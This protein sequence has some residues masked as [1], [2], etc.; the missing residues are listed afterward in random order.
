MTGFGR[1]EASRGAISATV[2]ARSVNQR[3]LKVS[4]RI[5]SWLS[6]LEPLARETVGREVRRGQVDVMVDVSG[7]GAR[8][9]VSID[10]EAVA[11]YLEEW[12]R[13]QH[14]L[15]IHGDLTIEVL[16]ASA[17][18]VTTSAPAQAPEDVWPVIEEALG[19][20]L[21]GLL[22]TRAVEGEATARDVLDRVEAIQ[23]G[24]GVIEERAPA[25]VR[26]HVERVGARVKD[27]LEGVGSAAGKL[28][29]EDMA[30]EVALLAEK[31]D[32]AEEVARLKSHIEQT[33]GLFADGDSEV[34]R[35]LEFLVQEM[36]REI[37]TIGSKSA[38]VEISRRV[39][40]VKAEIERV[41]EQA[42]NIE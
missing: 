1:G 23:S 14:E 19:G 12:R 6:S 32:V 7:E 37:N 15:N 2:E 25:A 36:V 11:N 4:V 40:E 41:R 28:S 26:E 34:G 10:A 24:L 8:P 27:L 20:A 5:P 42:R 29:E 31:S 9:R 30:R 18:L 38:D 13:V 33:R 3:F 39:V 16:A 17:D 21:K 35:R 22:A